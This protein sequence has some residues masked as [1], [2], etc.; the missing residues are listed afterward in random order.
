M[1]SIAISRNAKIRRSAAFRL[2]RTILV[3][4]A[5]LWERSAQ[6]GS[7]LTLQ[8]LIEP[9]PSRKEGPVIAFEEGLAYTAALASYM[10]PPPS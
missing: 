1:I 7:S 5:C 8:H 3:R 9:S 10:N 4:G 2:S 6:C